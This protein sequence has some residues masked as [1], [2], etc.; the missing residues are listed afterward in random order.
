MT[1]TLIF[2][3]PQERHK[4]WEMMSLLRSLVGF[5]DLKLQICRADGADY[6]SAMG[7]ARTGEREFSNGHDGSRSHNGVQPDDATGFI[8]LNAL[9]LKV[10]AKVQRKK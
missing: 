4:A 1:H 3:A 6:G 9:R 5:G 10:A 2:K 8:R 7:L